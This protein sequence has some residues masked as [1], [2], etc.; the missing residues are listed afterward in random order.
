[1]PPDWKRIR[2]TR[3]DDITDWVIHWTRGQHFEEESK[4]AMQVL[5]HI[6]QCGYLKPTFA[7][8]CRRPYRGDNSNTIEE[9][10]P[11]VCFTDQTLSAFIQSCTTLPGHYSPYGIALKKRNLFLYGG[12]P[13]IYGDQELLKQ[14]DD[15]HKYLWIRYYPFTDTPYGY[16]YDW[17]HER[18]WRARVKEWWWGSCEPT[19]KEGM[20]LVLLPDEYID[21]KLVP[22]LP[23]IL[24]QTLP[25][26]TA[27]RKWL[28]EF[29]E[30][31]ERKNFV[32]YLYAHFHQ[33]PIIPLDIV[34]ERLNAGD[35]RWARLET[36]PLNELA[37]LS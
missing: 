1:M 14:L 5:Q 27:L 36:L 29:P 37:F 32:T 7:P 10:Y 35:N 23:L 31:E 4:S 24:V 34:A 3:K 13:V 30:Y 33:L 26:A 19:P 25:E 2:D 21:G 28:L 20:P 9:P 18:E 15:D 17:T 6:L 22:P 16:P 12:R 8:R 11:A